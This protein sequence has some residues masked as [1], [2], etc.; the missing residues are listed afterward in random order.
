MLTGGDRRSIGRADEVVDIVRLDLGR[1]AELVECLWDADACVAVRG[2]DAVEKV[3]RENAGWLQRYKAA[4]LD[5]LLEAT[6]REV[7]W[8]LALIVP[9]MRLSPAESLRAAEILESYLE[10]RS[11]I[12]RTFA[13]QGLADLTLQHVSLRPKVLDL[14]R[15]LT[16]TG[17]PAMRA[18][19]RML[20]KELETTEQRR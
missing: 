17:T 12:V 4:L 3:S 7:R 10:D 14:I 6:Q 11:S 1:I 15:I 18:R 5:L 16:R 13:M 2:A 19:G 9:R 8:H 20:L